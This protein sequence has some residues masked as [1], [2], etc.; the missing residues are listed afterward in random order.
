MSDNRKKLLYEKQ[1]QIVK[2]MAHP[3]RIAVLDYLRDGE[4]CVCDIAEHI[5]C[6]RS[7]VSQHLSVMLSAGIL[8]CRKDGLNVMYKL[9]APCV[10]G[11][12]DCITNCLKIQ[13][14]ENRRLLEVL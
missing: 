2:A 14:K 13:A 7:N 3:V 8:E 5:G 9:K 1:A 12:F 10:L 4:R 6:E 11:F